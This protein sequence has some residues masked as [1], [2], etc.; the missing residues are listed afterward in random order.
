M[1]DKVKSRSPDKNRRAA[2]SAVRLRPDKPATAGRD[3]AQDDNKRMMAKE[4]QH[5]AFCGIALRD[6]TDREFSRFLYRHGAIG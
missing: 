3:S 5:P 1:T 6:A 4:S 2:K